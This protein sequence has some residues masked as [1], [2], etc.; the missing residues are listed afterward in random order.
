MLQF[1]SP[2]NSR[3]HDWYFTHMWVKFTFTV[4]EHEKILHISQIFSIFLRSWIHSLKKFR[5]RLISVIKDS[6]AFSSISQTLHESYFDHISSEQHTK[7]ISGWEKRAEHLFC[8][9]QVVTGGFLIRGVLHSYRF[10]I[11]A[12]RNTNTPHPCPLYL[13]NL[14]I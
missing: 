12:N 9:R 1:F 8:F 14:R 2:W 7:N 10:S 4:A 13:G 6:E 3:I 11:H 5:I